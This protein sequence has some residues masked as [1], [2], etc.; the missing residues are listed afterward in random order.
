MKYKTLIIRDVSPYNHNGN[1]FIVV[2]GHY[3]GQERVK[4]KTV[5]THWG[6]YH[7][8]VTETIEQAFLKLKNSYINDYLVAINKMLV[9]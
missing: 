9:N 7:Y 3:D 5:P 4:T 6:T 2:E 1:K 8:P